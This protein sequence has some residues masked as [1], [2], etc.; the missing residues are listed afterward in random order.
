MPYSSRRWCIGSDLQSF[1]VHSI[2]ISFLG[3]R[4]AIS[5]IRKNPCF[6][7]QKHRYHLKTKPFSREFEGIFMKT[8]LSFVLLLTTGVAHAQIVTQATSNGSI[9]I[10]P[11]GFIGKSNNSTTASTALGNSALNATTTGTNNTAFGYYTLNDVTTGTSNTAVGSGV[12]R[13]NTTGNENTGIGHLTLGSTTTGKGNTAGGNA[14]LY[15]NTEGDRNTAF[16]YGA[17]YTNELGQ[18]NSANGAYAL[19]FN[20]TGV[21]NTAIGY[22]SLI[23]N[24]TGD[25]NTAIGYNAGNYNKTG[26]NNTFLGYNADASATGLTNA[27]AIGYNAT[28]MSSNKV[29]IG[30]GSVTVI[31]GAVAWSTPSD[32]RLKENIYYTADLGL[33]F[34]NKLQTVSYNYISDKTHVRHDGFIAQDIEQ[35]MK[36]LKVE[37]SGLKKSEDGTY[38]LV[39][40]DFIMPLVNA[41]KELKEQN[42][43]Q[44][45]EINDLKQKLSRME[46]L[47]K[48]LNVL[49]ASLN[50]APTGK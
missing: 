47:E 13:Y 44:Q 36:E 20:E 16:G 3:A 49:E 42:N 9:T 50:S 46:E 8:I 29:R 34:I 10:T 48:R 35:V 12:L 4:P 27:T 5:Y 14:A 39:Y 7:S 6:P 24:T 22:N 40:S 2:G 43:E 41:A 19:Y 37:F 25:N 28:V 15:N 30:N 45:T 21:N 26:N 33:N 31:E 38:S 18:Y 11:K 32:R 1:T 23:Y 17:L